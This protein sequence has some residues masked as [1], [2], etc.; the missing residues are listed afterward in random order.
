MNRLKVG[1]YISQ[2]QSDTR[3]V[4]SAVFAV[5]LLAFGLRLPSSEPEP[6]FWGFFASPS[7][8]AR[9]SPDQSD[10]ISPLTILH[11]KS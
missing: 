9:V 10:C 7:P 8:P 5:G 2:S 3:Q 6:F 4:S 1:T 11:R